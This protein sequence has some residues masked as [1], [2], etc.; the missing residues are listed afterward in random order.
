MAICGRVAQPLRLDSIP[1]V[2]CYKY[3]QGRPRHP[4]AA[5]LCAQS[6]F[7]NGGPS[8]RALAEGIRASVV[9]LGNFFGVGGPAR[10]GLGG[11][12]GSPWPYVV[13]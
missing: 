2:T 11:L 10:L 6:S 4:S 9:G 8:S 3:E 12:A 5:A 7:S 1:S 13:P